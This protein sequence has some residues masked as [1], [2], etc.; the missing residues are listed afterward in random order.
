MCG[1][2][3]EEWLRGVVVLYNVHKLFFKESFLIAVRTCSI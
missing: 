3:E 1:I 2:I